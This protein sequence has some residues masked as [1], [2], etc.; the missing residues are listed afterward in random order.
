VFAPWL[1][2]QV[3]DQ[4][5]RWSREGPSSARRLDDTEHA[6]RLGHCSAL[7]RKSRAIPA[8]YKMLMAM[9]TDAIAVHPTRSL[10]FPATL[11]LPAHQKPRS[12]T[13]MAAPRRS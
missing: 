8:K 3:A 7:D 13:S 4:R 6:Q 9:V 11:A 12:G 2:P 5:A 1:L 10:P